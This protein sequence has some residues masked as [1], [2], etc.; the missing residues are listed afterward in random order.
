MTRWLPFEWIAALRFL[1]DGWTQTLF[2]LAGVSV[3]VA[4]IVFMSALLSGLQ[5]NFL[6]RVLSAQAHIVMLTPDEVARPLRSGDGVIQDAVVQRPAQRVRSIDQWQTILRQ[7]EAMPQIAVA[8]PVASGAGLAVRG[9]ASRSITLTGVEP[10]GYFRIVDLPGSM[11]S[12]QLRLNAEDIVIGSDLATN[13]GVTVGDKLRV[14]AG[15]GR[16][17]TQTISGIFD[18]GNRAVNERTTFV[19][20]RTAQSLLGLT[21]GVTSLQ[22][23]LH[24][25]YA[26]EVLAQ[27]IQGMTGMRADSWIRTNLQFFTAVS[28]Q[29]TTNTVIR[30]SV[31]LSVALGMASVLVVSVVQRSR[32]IGILRAMG[33]RR[34]QILRIFLIQGGVLGVLG[35][36]I[37]SA[38]ALGAL[39]LF[40]A[41]ARQADG[42]EI[43]PLI[44]EPSLF[45][46]AALLAGLTGVLAA[47]APAMRAARLNPVEAIRG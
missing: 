7:M 38:L 6:R 15:T 42:T 41:S 28:A 10:D 5:T 16:S 31:G 27:A 40:H 36:F 12:G 11:T 23:T 1:R 44:V 30:L 18:L 35:S 24:D 8:T 22:L 45:V 19:A 32:E 13:L 34:G 47:M 33:A 43:F 29:R 25:P 20:L 26:A 2:I 14:T 46:A 4:V 17:A 21:G 9:E 39:L 37:G 3:G